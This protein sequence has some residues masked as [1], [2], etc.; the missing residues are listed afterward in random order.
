[1]SSEPPRPGAIPGWGQPPDA[2]P[3]EPVPGQP[4]PPAQ[5]APAPAAPGGWSTGSPP[6]TPPSSPPPQAP[7][8]APPTTGWGAA[9][10][11]GAV[12]PGTVPG[13]QPGWNP[14]VVPPTRSNNGC[15]K[16]CLIVAAILAILFVIG[17]GA[18]VFIG[19]QI[20]SSV[21][22]DENGNIGAPCPF[23]SNSELSTALGTNAQALELKGFFDA[24][25]GLILDKRVLPDAEDCWISNNGSTSSSSATGRMARYQGSDAAAVYQQ[26]WQKAQPSSQP[27]GSGL[28]IETEGYFGGDVTGFGDEA[29]CTSVSP[30]IQGGIL[31]RQGDTLVYVSLLGSSASTADVCQQAQVVA[32]A[33]LNHH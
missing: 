18:L 24:T 29:F 15:L 33:I 9:P 32:Q 30:A 4:A 5:P 13:A 20:V 8:P 2:T 16:A 1:M 26:E 12:P 10:A 17:I 31:V 11:P 22:V 28:S 3:T 25:I 14:E 19:N 21:G 23:I 6:P 27:Q 7:A